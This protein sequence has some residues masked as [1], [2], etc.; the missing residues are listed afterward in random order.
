[1]ITGRSLPAHRLRLAAGRTRHVRMLVRR[2]FK[3]DHNPWGD[4]SL[5]APLFEDGTMTSGDTIMTSLW[6]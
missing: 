3:A 4:V 5:D 2:S 1:M 6:Q